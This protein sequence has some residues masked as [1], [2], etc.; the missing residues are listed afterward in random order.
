MYVY[1]YIHTNS[2]THI[3][4]HKCIQAYI[5]T[6]IPFLITLH[7]YGKKRTFLKI[8]P[9]SCINLGYHCNPPPPLNLAPLVQNNKYVN[10]AGLWLYLTG[11]ANIS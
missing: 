1:I 7:R 10:N 6:Y 2:P 3:H 5:V 8:D 9:G 4:M 11:I